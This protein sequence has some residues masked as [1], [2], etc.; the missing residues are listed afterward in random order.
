MPASWP[1]RISSSDRPYFACGRTLGYRRGTVSVLWFRMS[2]R[3]SITSCRAQ[4]TPRKSGMSTSIRTDGFTLR[5]WR[6]V[7]ANIAAPPSGSSS[8]F[9]DVMTAWRTSMRR[10]ASATRYGSSVSR[11]VGRPVVTAQNPQERV[12][13]SPSIM[14]VA[15]PAFQHSPIFGQRASS[16]TVLSARPRI[17]PLRSL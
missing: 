15:V 7:S 2:G 3:S 14:N 5:A 13:T 12:Q 9:T 17:R 16:H 4:R 6:I 10:I 8:R 1:R 11:A